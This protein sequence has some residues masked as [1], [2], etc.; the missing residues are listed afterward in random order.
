[1]GQ[2]KPATSGEAIKR[3]LVGLW[4]VGVPN[5]QPLSAETLPAAAYL[6]GGVKPF[7]VTASFSAIGVMARLSRTLPPQTT[8]K[9]RG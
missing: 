8:A 5:R 9:L 6:A 3:P 7:T 4:L 1:M 2:R